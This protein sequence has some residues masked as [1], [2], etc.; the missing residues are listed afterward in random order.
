MFLPPPP[1]PGAIFFSL[2]LFGFTSLT[3]VDALVRERAL[4]AREVAGGYYGAAEYLLPRLVGGGWAGVGDT[5]R[6]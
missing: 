5:G 6:W 4:V 3:S 2:C 1:P